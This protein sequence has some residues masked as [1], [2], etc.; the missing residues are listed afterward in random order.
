MRKY[1]AAFLFFLSA[2]AAD[3]QQGLIRSGF[4]YESAPFPECHA[5][6]IEETKEGFIAA[7]F[8]GTGEKHPDVG[9][10]VSRLVNDKWTTPVEVANGIQTEKKRFPCWNPVLFQPKSGPLMLFYKVGPNPEK[11][12]GMV[13][14]SEDGGKTWSGSRKLDAG[15]IGP[16][17]NKPL[18]LANGDILS[19]SSSENK[20]YRV[21]FEKSSDLGKRWKLIGPIN[22]GKKIAAIQPCFLR[23][24]DGRLQAIGRTGQDYIFTAESSDSGETWSAMTLMALPNPDAGTDAITL[25]DGRHLLVYNHSKGRK[26]QW[27]YGRQF[28]N[29]AISKDGINWEAALVL[30]SHDRGEYSYPA[31]IQSRDGL[32]HATYTWRR[33]KIRH[34]VIDPSK[35][36]LRPIVKGAWPKP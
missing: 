4:I 15:V 7:W 20:G 25:A 23:H 14:T 17:K 1:F 2:Q 6:T 28:L 13:T 34:V 32:V 19:G 5:S 16:V 27:D 10:W 29:V 22:D 31:V 9:I 36:E 26:S 12:W 33:E 30:E 24:A 3:S 11:W 35:L 21:H 18:Q 8:G